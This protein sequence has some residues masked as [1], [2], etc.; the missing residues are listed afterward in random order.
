[1]WVFLTDCRRQ[2]LAEGLP[3]NITQFSSDLCPRSEVTYIQLFKAVVGYKTIF[4]QSQSRDYR[5][6]ILTESRKKIA[7]FGR[8][9]R[10][11]RQLRPSEIRSWCC[12]YS[13]IHGMCG[14]PSISL[15]L[16]WDCKKKHPRELWARTRR[17]SL[18]ADILE[19]IKLRIWHFAP[20][21]FIELAPTMCPRVEFRFYYL[22]TKIKFVR[23][24]FS[25][26]EYYTATHKIVWFIWQQLAGTSIA[27]LK[28]QNQ[29]K[30]STASSI[31]TSVHLIQH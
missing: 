8:F 21:Q 24:T 29:L 10:Y 11:F 16:V 28:S 20:H 4:D 7:I 6:W 13:S 31:A 2:I 23:I 19:E 26:T 17:T 3:S 30:T 18:I 1:M 27:I 22:C 25:P 12:E 14:I 5:R 15:G 9:M